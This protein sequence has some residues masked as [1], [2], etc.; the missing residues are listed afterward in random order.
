[1]VIFSNVDSER[2][3]LTPNRPHGCCSETPETDGRSAGKQ[4]IC[5]FEGCLESDMLPRYGGAWALRI[6]S[7]RA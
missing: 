2:A 6:R 7:T 1:M 4:Q 5:R 3:E